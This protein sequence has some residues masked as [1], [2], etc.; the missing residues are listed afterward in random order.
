MEELKLLVS[1]N[2]NK[3]KRKRIVKIEIKRKEREQ[4]QKGITLKRYRQKCEKRDR[5]MFKMMNAKIGSG[6]VFFIQSRIKRGFLVTSMLTTKTFKFD[7][8]YRK[9]V[10]KKK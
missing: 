4:K 1:N 3:E 9:S 5:K 8:Q 6:K 7:S 10:F 2:R